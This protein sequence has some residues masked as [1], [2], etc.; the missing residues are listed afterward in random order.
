MKEH[1]WRDSQEHSNDDEKQGR[2][3]ERCPEFQRF[4]IILESAVSIYPQ[5]VCI[6]GS[7][8]QRKNRQCHTYPDKP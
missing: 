5:V 3:P 4:L 2:K 1:F 8:K 6:R 7:D